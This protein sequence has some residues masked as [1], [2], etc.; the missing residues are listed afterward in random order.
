M[1]A[2]LLA[3]ISLIVSAE[4]TEFLDKNLAYRSPFKGWDEVSQSVTCLL[5]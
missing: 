2:Q 5:E 3:A 1:L 4:A